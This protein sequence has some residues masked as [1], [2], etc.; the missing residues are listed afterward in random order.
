MSDERCMSSLQMMAAVVVI[1]SIAGVVQFALGMDETLRFS[2]VFVILL[3]LVWTRFVLSD[4]V[5]STKHS[6]IASILAS[7]AIGAFATITVHAFMFAGDFLPSTIML[8]LTVPY[9]I[10]ISLLSLQLRKE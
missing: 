8:A 3:G 4:T 6:W 9:W 7:A 1:R 2:L 5:P 10:A